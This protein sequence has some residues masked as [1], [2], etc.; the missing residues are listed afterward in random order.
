MDPAG[1]IGKLGFQRWYERELLLCHS[2]LVACLLCVFAL[3]ALLEDLSLRELGW[4]A[5]AALAAAFAAGGIAWYALA[6]YLSMLLRAMH[7]AERSTCPGC[8]AH[9]KYRLVGASARA[10]TVHCRKCERE[11]A[12]D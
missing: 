9:G 6:R 2:W 5:A 8:G 11:W 3:L 12:I 10:M 7:V 1:A 4:G